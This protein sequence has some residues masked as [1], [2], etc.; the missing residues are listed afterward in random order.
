[1]NAKKDNKSIWQRC[2]TIPNL[3]SIFRLI[4][5]PFF[6]TAYCSEHNY[7]KTAVILAISGISDIVDGYIAR[8]FNMVS[9]F[10]KIID[11]VADKITQAAMLLCLLTRFPLM[12]LPLLLAIKEVSTGIS[13][14]IVIKKT[15]LVMSADWHG[16]LTTGL[17]YAMM[18]THIIWFDIPAPVSNVM[19][20]I[21]TAVMLMSFLLYLIRNARAIRLNGTQHTA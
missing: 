8:R 18:L 17:L 15:G 7:W 10:G 9:D 6:V 1:M 19:I 5:I 13:S 12:L 20:G 14:I 11:P 3:L 16:K 4:L 21:C 2:F